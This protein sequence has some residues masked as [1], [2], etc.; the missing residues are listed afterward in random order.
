MRKVFSTLAA[1]AGIMSAHVQAGTL[2][3]I[4]DRAK[5]EIIL[6]PHKIDR[7]LLMQDDYKG[8]GKNRNPLKH[9]FYA[10]NQRQYRKWMRQCPTMRKA[11]STGATIRQLVFKIESSRPAVP[12]LFQSLLNGVFHRIQI[13]HRLLFLQ[14]PF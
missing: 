6:V 10:G 9:K 12:R 1:V 5:E 14:Q 11:K 4:A 2:H 8:F 7:P 13:V 3:K